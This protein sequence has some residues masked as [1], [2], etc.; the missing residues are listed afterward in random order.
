MTPIR[1][2]VVVLASLALLLAASLVVA[3]PAAAT[4]NAP[5][6]TT[7]DQW[8]Y[9]VWHRGGGNTS[10]VFTVQEQT[11]LTLGSGV[12]SVWHVKEAAIATSGGST[13]ISWDD[14]WIT[15][16]GARVAKYVT[17]GVAI[18]GNTTVTYDPPMPQAVFPLNPGD[19]WSVP[20]QTHTQNNL[21]NF[22]VNTSYSGFVTGEQSVGVP[23]GTFS[24]AAIRSPT[25]GNPY[26]LSY[27][28]E[29][30]GWFVQIQSYNGQGVLTSVQNLTAYKYSGY[31]ILGVPYVVWI[32]LLIVVL[33]L[34]VAVAVLLHRRRPPSPYAAPP[35]GAPGYPP[36]Q[37]PAP[38]P[39]PGPP[40][41]P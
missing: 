22:T 18:L 29:Q 23:A 25:T 17:T 3:R 6:M 26:T 35:Q 41:Q 34:V 11:T 13:V 20:S 21:F 14:A 39:P 1:K 32:L 40:P 5:S 27:F 15:A 7:G 24:A 19:S 30:A 12:Y 9:N 2:V 4:Q 38:P 31:G 16:D 37:P 8:T 33:A 36:Y 10:L 28:S